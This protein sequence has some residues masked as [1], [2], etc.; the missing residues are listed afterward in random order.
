MPAP[1]NWRQGRPWPALEMI[2]SM[3]M[4]TLVAVTIVLV[5]EIGWLGWG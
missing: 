4:A 1:E 2:M 5:I 3:Q